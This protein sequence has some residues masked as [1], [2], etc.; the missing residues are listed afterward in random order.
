MTELDRVQSQYASVKLADGA[1]MN[2]MAT[3]GSVR[4]SARISRHRSQT[5]NKTRSETTPISIA[6][7]PY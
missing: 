2:A 1:N 5:W 7:S 6:K 4:G 3:I